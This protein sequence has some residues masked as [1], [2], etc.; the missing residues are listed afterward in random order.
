M[1][2][3]GYPV[4]READSVR[5]W[6]PVTNGVITMRDVIWLKR[7]FFEA[8]DEAFDLDDDGKKIEPEVEATDELQSDVEKEYDNIVELLSGTKAEEAK[9]A[10]DES[11]AE[12]TDESVAEETDV[13]NATTTQSG[14]T[15]QTPV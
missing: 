6:N 12:E 2:L 13:V 3:V 5:M 7:M 11:V 9:E 10:D 4:N 14:R 8:E 1:M 15:V